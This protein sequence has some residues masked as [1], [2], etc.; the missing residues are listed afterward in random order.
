MKNPYM[1]PIKPIIAGFHSGQENIVE[2]GQVREQ[3]EKLVLELFVSRS[4]QG[5]PNVIRDLYRDE[6]EWILADRTL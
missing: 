2:V 4:Y 6:K 3:D 5:S 1:I